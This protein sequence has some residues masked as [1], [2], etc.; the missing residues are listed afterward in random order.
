MSHWWIDSADEL[1]RLVE[2]LR[3]EPAIALDTEFHR[4]RTYHPHAALLQFAWGTAGSDTTT[5]QIAL[6]DALAVDLRP[7]APVI[8]GPAT[9]VMHAAAQDLEVLA[10]SCGASPCALFDTQIAAGFAGYSNPSLATLIDGVLGIRLPKG[11]RLADWLIRPLTADQC[12]YAASD[13]AHLLAVHRW[14]VDRL[15][16]DGRMSWVDD[17]CRE[18]LRRGAAPRDPNEAWWRLKEARQLRGRAIG[19][20]QAVAAWRERRAGETDQPV[21]HVLPDLALV[22]IAQ[23]PPDTVDA[24]HRVRGLDERHLRGSAPTELLAAVAEGLRMPRSELRLPPAGDVDR[25]LRPAVA[26]ISAWIAQLGKQLQIDT[27]LLATRAD[28]EAL[29]R[30]D[31]SARLAHGWRAD[32][33]GQDIRRLVEGRAA[34]AFEPRGGLVLEDRG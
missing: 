5:E 22:S 21:R 29:L 23:R 15:T 24:L 32:A 9:I 4:E 25:E 34:L 19:V 14:L 33:L 20:A 16:G 13:V 30:G 12:S 28:I 8:S 1:D 11:D 18:M 7:L 26:L 31:E 3:P 10:R 27:T 6:V 2:A 17:E